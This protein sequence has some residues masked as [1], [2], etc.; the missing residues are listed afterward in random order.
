MRSRMPSDV[1]TLVSAYLDQHLVRNRGL[2]PRTRQVYADSLLLFLRYVSARTGVA[3]DRLQFGDLDPDTVLAFLAYLEEE[4]GNSVRSRNLRLCALKSFF[5]YAGFRN[6]ALLDQVSRLNLIQ[7]KRYRKGVVAYLDTEEVTAILD[8]PDLATP[9]GLRDR[10][11]LLVTY[12]YGLRVSEALNLSLGDVWLGRNPN[13]AVLGK[14]GRRDEMPLLPQHVDVLRAWIDARPKTPSQAVFLN[15]V[16]EPLTR[17]GFAYLLTKYA[18][19]AARTVPSIGRKRITPHV[20]RHSCAMAILKATKDPR[21]A[22]R[23]LR[24]VGYRSIHIYLHADPEEKLA[25]VTAHADLGIRAGN[26]QDR[27]PGVLE[28]LRSASRRKLDLIEPSL[29]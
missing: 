17:D 4:R 23:Q 26:F 28:A 5:G 25:T 24:H 3:P 12:A 10:A 7:G 13:M 9:F 29:S 19:I 27:A 18:K 1:P 22:A 11:L 16:G 15:R 14:G 20:L 21:K 8:A 2:S 6:P